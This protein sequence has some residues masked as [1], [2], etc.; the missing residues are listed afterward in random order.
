VIH[1]KAER[2]TALVDGAMEMR[3]RDFH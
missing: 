3:S 2:L 1:V